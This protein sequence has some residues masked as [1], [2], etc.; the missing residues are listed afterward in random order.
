MGKY[1]NKAANPWRLP[2]DGIVDEEAIR[3]CISGV[4]KVALTEAE[5]RLAIQQMIRARKY[6]PNDICRTVGVLHTEVQQ[7][8][9]SIGYKVVVDK[10]S[11]NGYKL[12][13]PVTP[14][15]PATPPSNRRTVDPETLP[16]QIDLLSHKRIF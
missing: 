10:I 9:E 2:E 14:D 6:R 12:F 16:D 5:R 8:A 1:K 15:E 13:V 4:R 7:I 3:L 11:P